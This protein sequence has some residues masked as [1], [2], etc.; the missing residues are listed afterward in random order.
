MVSNICSRL[1]LR[2]KSLG[3]DKWLVNDIPDPIPVT[4]DNSWM[5]YVLVKMFMIDITNLVSI[6]ASLCKQFHI[7][8]NAVDK[9]VYWEYEM[10]M[11]I[12]N[13]QVKSEN[14][15]N[16]AEMKKYDVEG[17]M[18]KWRNPKSIQPKMPD[19]GSMKMPNFSSTKF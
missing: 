15:A 16:E 17:T 18:N 3:Q 13:D 11:K 5:E 7:D 12:L 1:K 14:E 6:K 10:F 4:M 2:L 19:F 9:M 8:P